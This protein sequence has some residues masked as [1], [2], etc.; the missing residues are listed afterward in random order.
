MVSKQIKS[1]NNV[2][3]VYYSYSLNYPFYWCKFISF[4]LHFFD[5]PS[6]WKGAP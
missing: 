1:K 4:Y 6:M 5:W 3:Q 2:Y